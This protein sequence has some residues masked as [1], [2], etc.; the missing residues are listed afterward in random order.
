MKTT[1]NFLQC[2]MG[3]Q[4]DLSVQRSRI[5]KLQKQ[6]KSMEA[7]FATFDEE[8]RYYAIQRNIQFAIRKTNVLENKIIHT[9]KLLSCSAN[10]VP[11][12][13]T[14]FAVTNEEE[15]FDDMKNNSNDFIELQNK[16]FN[17]IKESE[18]STRTSNKLYHTT[19]RNHTLYS[20]P[21]R[22]KVSNQKLDYS[23][24]HAV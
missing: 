5:N 18:V 16:F 21:Y 22:A 2:C 1:D 17:Y 8:E 24:L 19:L 23:K 10:Y 12:T 11:L 9:I 4:T 3:W 20:I 7:N 13:E 14:E 6:L 15:L